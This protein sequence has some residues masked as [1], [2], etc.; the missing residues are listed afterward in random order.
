MKL[1]ALVVAA[2]P[3]ISAAFGYLPDPDAMAPAP[4]PGGYRFCT[5]PTGGADYGYSTFGCSYVSPD[6]DTATCT[7]TEGGNYLHDAVAFWMECRDAAEAYYGHIS[8]W[9]VGD[10]TDF[11]SAFAHTDFNDDI[12]NWD[13]SSATNM[14]FMFQGTTAFNQDLS[15]WD[16][17]SVTD[18]RYMF[19]EAYA[20]NQW[21]CWP[22]LNIDYDDD[23]TL[24]SE[25]YSQG[26]QYGYGNPDYEGGNVKVSYMFSN[27]CYCDGCSGSG[28]DLH[29]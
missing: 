21:L 29:C 27:C 6:Y 18:M 24:N 9:D 17:S 20:F 15:N 23:Q 12:T 2:L 11:N 1:T 19:E 10:V 7:I 16:I 8:T 13:V 22:N 25:Y 28:I 26:S 5:D 4:T 3:A 14:Q